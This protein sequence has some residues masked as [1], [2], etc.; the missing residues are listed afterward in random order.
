MAARHDAVLGN[1]FLQVANL[2]APPPSLL[3]PAVVMRVIWGNLG[4]HCARR[5]AGT[6]R[7][8]NAQA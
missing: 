3:H 5:S 8:S 4:R 1:A 2:Q 6:R 7:G